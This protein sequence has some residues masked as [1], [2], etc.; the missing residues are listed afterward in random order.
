MF[1]IE[2]IL[3]LR[4]LASPGMDWLMATVS[5]LGYSEVYGTIMFCLIFGYHLKKGLAVMVAAFLVGLLTFSLKNGLAFPRPSD[6]DIRVLPVDYEPP[7][8]LNKNGVGETFW[9][10]PSQEALSLA[11]IQQN[12]SYGLPSGHV[13]AATAFLLGIAL[14]F[15]SKK[16]LLFSLGWIPLMCMSRMYLGRHFL[17]DVLGGVLV[18]VLGVWLAYLL[19]KK[20]H[21]SGNVHPHLQTM[22]PLA[23]LVVPLVLWAPFLDLIHKE[24]AGRVLSILIFYVFMI[25]TGFPSDA[26]AFWQ[27][28]MRIIIVIILYVLV[29]KTFDFVLKPKEWAD[30]PVVAMI[31]MLFTNALAF[32]GGT[33]ILRRVGLYKG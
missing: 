5:K 25:S 26:G 10:L 27:R 28:L 18:G 16:V 32:V 30:L 31:S 13:S 17:A 24:N 2:P 21:D 29:D 33:F 12:W 8:G 23:F 7:L 15:R 3:W 4:A 20:F 22:L 9:D 1:Q 6:I 14:F 11:R 19:L